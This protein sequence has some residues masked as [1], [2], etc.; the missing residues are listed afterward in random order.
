MKVVPRIET[1]NS[2]ID[3]IGDG[4]KVIE[5]YGNPRNQDKIN[6]GNVRFTR[7]GQVLYIIVDDVYKG[8][9][10]HILEFMIERLKQRNCKIIINEKIYFNKVCF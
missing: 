4:N 9:N 2:S 3:I 10:N 7:N 6:V 1:N 5:I 8:Y